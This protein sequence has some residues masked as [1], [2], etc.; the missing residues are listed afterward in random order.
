ML[1]NCDGFSMVEM[2]AAFFVIVC[3]LFFLVLPLYHISAERE[4]LE[5]TRI[6]LAYLHDVLHEHL[7]EGNV[8]KELSRSLFQLRMQ[9]FDSGMIR[10]CASWT[11]K[12]KPEEVCVYGKT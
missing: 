6:A 3:C 7:S 8:S 9:M 2:L 12:G 11:Y 1:R 10:Y 4:N 5:R